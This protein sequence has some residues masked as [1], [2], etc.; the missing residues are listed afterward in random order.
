MIEGAADQADPV[1]AALATFT[2]DAAGHQLTFLP[3]GPQRLDRLLRLI[4]EARAS[5]NMAFYIFA[6]DT[7]GTAVRDALV[8]AAQRGVAVRLIVDDFGTGARDAFFAPL[9]AAGG[10]V[11]TFLPRLSRR[12]LIRNHQKLV[13]ADGAVAMLG[14][15]NVADDY[16]APPGDDSWHDLGFTIAGPTVARLEQWFAQLEQLA[17]TR[18]GQFR[19]ILRAVGQWDRGADPLQVLIGGP[20]RGLSSWARMV[21]ADLVH[22]TRLDLVMAY[23]APPRRLRQRIRRIAAKG[24]S[25]LLLAG[26]TDNAATI[27]A[28]RLLYRSLLRSG[29]QL[30]EYQ[31]A[32][33]HMK[34][35]V[36]DDAVYL[37]SANFDMRSL[38]LNL[39]IML[40]I[41]DAALAERLRA[42]VTQQLGEAQRITPAVHRAQGGW[43]TRVR[44]VI[45]WFLVSVLDYSV[46]RRLNLGL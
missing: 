8:A 13:I 25:R 21:S 14:G 22:G 45:S 41:R 30:W 42:F 44:W 40:R 36:L 5:L 4:G 18:R 20:T 31:P 28:S 26:K 9:A 24:Q 38:Y 32:R 46:S 1:A 33:L 15:F 2:C 6:A 35:I 17:G 10:T 39:E 3:G 43:S 16:F 37:G 12:Y 29:A 27:G 7:A 19:A 34:L 11:S 23:F